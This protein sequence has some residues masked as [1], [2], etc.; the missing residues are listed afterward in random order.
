MS[1]EGGLKAAELCDAIM[2]SYNR[3]Y[4]RE[5]PVIE[6][7]Q[8]LGRGVVIKKGF[9]SG[10]LNSEQTAQ[11]C[12]QEILSLGEGVAVTVGTINPLHLEENIRIAKGVSLNYPKV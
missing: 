9:C 3:G 11:D 5:L 4:K 2:V 12:L 1:I 8:Q 7:A 6:R 10:H